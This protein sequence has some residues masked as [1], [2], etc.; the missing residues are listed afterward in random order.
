MPG[1]NTKRE[2]LLR[3]DKKQEFVKVVAVVRLSTI[4][5]LAHDSTSFLLIFQTSKAHGYRWKFLIESFKEKV[6]TG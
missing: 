3:T 6:K 1:K 2:V 5:I 4:K